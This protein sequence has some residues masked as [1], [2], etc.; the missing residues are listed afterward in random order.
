M[1]QITQKEADEMIEKDKE[2]L[3]KILDEGGKITTT[4]IEEKETTTI[5]KKI[6]PVNGQATSSTTILKNDEIS[7]DYSFIE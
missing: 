1:E 5:T 7:I 6:E 2:E 4:I 3:K